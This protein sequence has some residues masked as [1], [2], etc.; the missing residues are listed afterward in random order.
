LHLFAYRD[1]IIVGDR[2]HLKVSL[3]ETF[4]LLLKGFPFNGESKV[5]VYDHFGASETS[6]DSNYT[7]RFVLIRESAPEKYQQQADMG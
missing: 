1:T 4:L 2:M 5:L 3:V 6:E 7:D